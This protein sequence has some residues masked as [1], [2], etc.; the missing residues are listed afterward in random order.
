MTLHL[1]IELVAIN[2]VLSYYFRTLQNF[3]TLQ[4]NLHIKKSDLITYQNKCLH[5]IVKHAYNS[6]PLYRKKYDEAGIKPDEINTIQDLSKLPCVTKNEIRQNVNDAVS[7]KFDTKS[8]HVLSTSGSTGTPLKIFITKEEDGYR[9]AKHLRANFN[10]GHYPFDRWLTITSPSHFS[11]ISGFQKTL[12]FYSPKFVSVFGDTK[13]QLSFINKYKPIVLDGYSSSLAI[14]AREAKKTNVSVTNPRIIFGGAELCD[15]SSR[16]IIEEVFKAPFYDQYATV[17]FERMAWQCPKKEG[18]HIDADSLIMQFLDS[19]GDEVSPGESGKI[20][21]TS[22]FN[23]AMPFIKYVVG[24]SGV[25]SDDQCS[26]GRTLPL[27]E[28]I[29]GRSDALL[30]LPQGRTLSPRTITISMGK[31][32]LNKYIEQFKLIQT[33]KDKLEIQLKI[34]NSDAARKLFENGIMEKEITIHFKSM[35]GIETEDVT[36][37]V[38]F[39]DNIPLSKNGKMQIIESQINSK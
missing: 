26:C 2:D 27:M 29:E 24:D 11:E 5:K 19:H 4:R 30:F 15:D 17:E 37:A 21:C 22:L 14:V 16:E 20:V 18:Y 34:E 13:E 32:H 8:L 38:Q 10:C 6:V 9:K 33:R 39:V 31:F 36:F 25:Y 1:K 35:L 23:Y 3:I 7:T 12:N 28:K